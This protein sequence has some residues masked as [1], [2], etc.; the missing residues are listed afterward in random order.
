MAE[1]HGM[2]ISTMTRSVRRALGLGAVIGVL[3]HTGAVLAQEAADAVAAKPMPRVEI[4]GSAIKRIESE[5]ALPVQVITREE[6]DKVGVT[7]AS[8]ILARL[9][10]NVGGLT[11][12]ASINVGGDQRGFNSANLRGIGTSSTLVLL[13]GRRMANFASP[14]D[15]TGVDLNNIPA[16]AIQRV[17]VLLDGA[18]ALYG[19]DAIGGVINFITRKDY[20][21]VEL[22]AY[23]LKTQEG[24]A[25]K[26][27]ASVTAG[28]GDLAKDGFNVFAVAD[29]QKSNALSTSQR[30]FIGDLRVPQRLPHL[31]SGYTSPANIRLSS[32]QRDE[33]QAQ[34]FTING[35]PITNR[36][37]NPSVP[38]C[39]PP[40]NLYLPAGI[41]GV[42]ACT[43]DYM[44]DTELFPKS[45][46]TNLLTRGVL[47]ISPN[48]QLYAEVA[49]SHSKTW[50]IGSG[51]RAD[52]AEIDYKKIPAFAG[53]TLS[54]DEDA[55]PDAPVT[56][57]LRM[58]MNEAGRRATELTSDSQRYV[59]GLTGTANGWDYDVG[60]NHS[61][62]K[63]KDR[64][65]H[66]YLLKDRMLQGIAD[67]LINPFG[68]SSQAGVDLLNSIQVDDVARRARGTMDSVD[69][70]VSRAIGTLAGGDA[71]LAVGGE[72]RRERTSYTPSALLLSD[73][74]N[75]DPA[76]EEERANSNSRK[77]KAVFGELLLPFTKQ[78]EAQLSAR[79][80]HYQVVGGAASP[81]VGISYTPTK[82][83]LFRAS[84]G[85]GFRAPSMNDL[86]RATIYSSTA[87]LPDPQYCAT[88][89][90]SLADC[91]D[92]WSTRRYSNANLKPEHSRQ[93]S[94]GMVIQPTKN[95]SMT[96][97]YWNIKRT[98]LISEIG[99]DIILGNLAKY[100]NL[101]HRDEDGLIDYI[102]LRKENRGAQK[103]S[104]IDLVLDYNGVRTWAGNF[105]GRLSGTY[106]FTSKIQNDVGDPY[107]SNLGR[108]VTDGVVQ[109][110]RHTI[111]FDWDQGPYSATLSNT[112]SSAYNDQ[113]S[114]INTDDGTV[115][116]ANRVSSYSLW[117]LSGAWQV[118]KAFKLRAGIQNLF[119]KAPPFS[120]Q[121]YFFLSGY[122][123]TYTDPRGRRFYASASYAFK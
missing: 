54:P 28:F 104:G 84:A 43:Y 11:D 105:G 31:L 58:R 68:P 115:V 37:I 75:N 79:Y 110:W 71:A 65:T 85:R 78:W 3:G 12:G 39:A 32:A 35:K 25:G 38:T 56:V 83:M 30:D 14:G 98:D 70:K 99:D 106:V 49:L 4:T 18:S 52:D 1:L 41:G 111:N 102:E 40:A 2:R 6:I 69:F 64:D 55:D 16:A 46:K 94:T 61:V 103:A 7:T 17:E 42:D 118:N 73:N 36:T 53:Y 13:N 48:S 114:A 109:R 24:G 59:V 113:N 88:V 116:A 22:N 33:L 107:V 20:Q 76:P 123:P 122:D 26:R 23:G 34:N 21:G 74:I 80:D 27:K 29:V 91:A 10:A 44:R 89:D 51:A 92:N 82:T 77:V 66:G 95:A 62:N 112:F 5:T 63:I 108:F 19:T 15:D 57:G 81:K 47:Q 93:F 121:A 96:I 120:N 117:D 90:F 50:Y 100:G 60:L 67:G 9:S 86:Y 119:D 8:E 87:T 101:V 45:D 72:Y 97:D